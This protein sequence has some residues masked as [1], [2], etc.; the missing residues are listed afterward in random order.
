MY[1]KLAHRRSTRSWVW[2][3]A[4]EADHT[5]SLPYRIGFTNNT[6]Q[7]PGTEDMSVRITACHIDIINVMLL[8][9]VLIYF[10]CNSILHRNAM[11]VKIFQDKDFNVCAFFIYILR[12]FE[13]YYI[14]CLCTYT[15]SCV[16]MQYIYI[17]I[18]I[19][20]YESYKKVPLNYNMQYEQFYKVASNTNVRPRHSSS[21]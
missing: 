19:Y 21:G 11:T 2:H 7:K 9:L 17:Y 14:C 8:I 3:A 10:V 18:Y 1:P 16:C 4:R 6:K 12:V 15:Y 20:T 5:L 13:M